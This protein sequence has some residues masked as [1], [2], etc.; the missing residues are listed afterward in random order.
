M[1]RFWLDMTETQVA[2][3]L[4]CSVGTVKSQSSRALAALRASAG[5]V[6]EVSRERR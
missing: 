2:E 3:E 5:L 4:G 6:A 1:L